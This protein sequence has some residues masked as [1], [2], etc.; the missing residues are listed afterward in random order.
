M[1]SCLFFPLTQNYHEAY[2]GKARP[3]KCAIFCALFQMCEVISY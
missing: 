3:G 1:Q 2:N